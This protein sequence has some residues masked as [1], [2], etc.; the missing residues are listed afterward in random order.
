MNEKKVREIIA[1][2]IERSF[3]DK[4]PV[5]APEGY[6]PLEAVRGGL[7]HWVCVPFND[8]QVWCELRCLNYTQIKALGNYSNLEAVRDKAKENKLSTQDLIKYRNYQEALCRAV[9]NKPLFDDITALIGKEDFV[10]SEKRKRIEKLKTVD[11]GGFTAEQKK[12]IFDELQMLEMFLGY[13][14]PENTLDFLCGWATDNDIS[15]ASKVSKEMLLEA[16]IFAERAHKL[17]HEV[18]RGKFLDLNIND[19]NTA[20]YLIYDN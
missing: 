15:D 5:A 7:F 16:A 13:L 1:L 10:I 4:R 11:A 18:L 9:L 3:K 12:E 6:A 19:I 20:A 2:E 17:P 14:L 8:A